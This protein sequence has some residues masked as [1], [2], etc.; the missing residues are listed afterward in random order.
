MSSVKGP[1]FPRNSGDLCETL[2]DKDE[3]IAQPLPPHL[4]L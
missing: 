4:S 1:R 2:E 3:G